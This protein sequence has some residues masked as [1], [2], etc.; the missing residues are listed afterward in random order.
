MYLSVVVDS[1]E[2]TSVKFNKFTMQ[3]VSIV[4]KVSLPDG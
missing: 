1:A 3:F 2:D 4:L